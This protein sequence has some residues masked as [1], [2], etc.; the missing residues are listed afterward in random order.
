MD[1]K[2]I[3]EFFSEYYD[4]M[5]ADEE[6]TQHLQACHECDREYREY[7][8]LLN[9]IRVLPEPELPPYFHKNLMA[10]VRKHA[11]AQQMKHRRTTYRRI[12]LLAA[13]VLWAVVWVSGVFIYDNW[14]RQTGRVTEYGATPAATPAAFGI[15]PA[16]DLDLNVNEFNLDR[17]SRGDGWDDDTAFPEVSDEFIVDAGGG[18]QYIM[19]V[20]ALPHIGHP[21]TGDISGA[22]PVSPP[23]I[24][25]ATPEAVFDSD[26]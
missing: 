6:I 5:E 2:D 13:S 17:T 12:A 20:P 14:D 9:D 10:G 15:Q 24:G 4:S 25:G 7:R 11:Q 1:C 22:S 8:Q 21:W 16:M 26:I 19:P 23:E 18:M 3:Q